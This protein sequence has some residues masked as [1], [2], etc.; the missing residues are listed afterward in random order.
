MNPNDLDNK[1]PSKRP[2]PPSPRLEKAVVLLRTVFVIILAVAVL[3]II[4]NA[5]LL[6]PPRAQ[7]EEE[8][9]SE[10]PPIEKDLTPADPLTELRPFYSRGLSTTLKGNVTAVL[11]FVDDAES[12][13]DQAARTK[14]MNTGIKPALHYLEGEAKRYG[15]ELHFETVV[16][17]AEPLK[18]K[19]TVYDA[20]KVTEL[21]A[22][23]DTYAFF[24]DGF[25]PEIGYQS[26]YDLDR[27]MET[28]CP[29]S[30]LIYLFLFN[31]EGR[32]YKTSQL[33]LALMGTVEFEYAMLFSEEG[34]VR[35]YTVAHEILHL[36][37]A[38]DYYEPAKRAELA[39]LYYPNDIMLR[40]GSH[41]PYGHD[42]GDLTAF[43][44]GWTDTAP[45]L[46][47]HSAW[48]MPETEAEETAGDSTVTEETTEAVT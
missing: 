25:L 40:H 19:G 6:D 27:H 28:E 10:L 45:D 26:G 17:N 22:D 18:Y 41:G 24:G 14:V 37:G 44:V 7:R 9:E 8:T 11:F 23:S 30:E 31:K 21:L 4:Q 46:C 42:I 38:E 5:D 16:Y 12:S 48:W 32:S 29:S 34:S 1:T 47:Y 2:T 20:D 13:W 39:T 36:F 3:L 33:E 35:S 15:V 43:S